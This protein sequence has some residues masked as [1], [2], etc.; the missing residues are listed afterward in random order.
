MMDLVGCMLAE[1]MMTGYGYGRTDWVGY[2]RENQSFLSSFLTRKDRGI[3]FTVGSEAS[4][5]DYGEERWVNLDDTAMDESKG[6]E[7]E[8]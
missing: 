3:I 8:Q 5:Y 6:K 4:L 2:G 1:V 7:L